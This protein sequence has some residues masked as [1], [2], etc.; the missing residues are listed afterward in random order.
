METDVYSG[1]EDRLEGFIN[2]HLDSTTLKTLSVMDGRVSL[3]CQ[4]R[5]KHGF[6]RSDFI[7]SLRGLTE[8]ANIEIFFGGA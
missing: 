6:D 4:F 3:H 5:K 2:K 8:P 7:K 1:I